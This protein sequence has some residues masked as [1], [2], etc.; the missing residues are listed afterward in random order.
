M[1]FFSSGKV[2]KKLSDA[3]GCRTIEGWSITFRCSQCSHRSHCECAAAKTPRWWSTLWGPVVVGS[4]CAPGFR[5]RR[6]KVK[7]KGFKVKGVPFFSRGKKFFSQARK[8]GTEKRAL[9]WALISFYV[10]RKASTETQRPSWGSI[11]KIHPSI[12]QGPS[13]AV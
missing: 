1:I 3:G 12:L 13:A 4:L 9:S 6:F 5:S 2:S 10:I 7:V 11:S 8:I